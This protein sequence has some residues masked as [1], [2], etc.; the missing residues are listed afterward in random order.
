MTAAKTP[1]TPLLDELAGFDA[2]M[3]AARQR[4]RA[5]TDAIAEHARSIEELKRERIDAY[6][7][8]DE[9]KAAALKKRTVDAAAKAV[10]LDERRQ[11]ADIAATKAQRE[12]DAFVAEN[13]AALVSERIPVATA[14]VKQIEDAIA[15]LGEGVRLWTAE[16]QAQVDLLRPIP[17]RD[18]R[19]VPELQ[20]RELVRDLRRA[21][22]DGVPM[23]VPEVREK[24]RRE[25]ADKSDDVRMEVFS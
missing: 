20:C 25:L 21:T 7:D 22:A 5:L 9:R 16:Q 3:A 6:S 17:G 10:E 4:A 19:E 13:H 1:R 12:R 8:D 18:G 15:A 24:A 11:G 23:P 2:R 14:A